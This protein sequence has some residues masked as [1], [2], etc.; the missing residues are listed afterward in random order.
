M[1]GVTKQFHALLL[2]ALGTQ[3]LGRGGSPS[4]HHHWWFRC[5]GY[6]KSAVFKLVRPGPKGSAVS[7]A[8]VPSGK[9]KEQGYSRQIFKNWVSR[10]VCGIREILGTSHL[11]PNRYINPTSSLVRVFKFSKTYHKMMLSDDEVNYKSYL[12]QTLKLFKKTESSRCLFSAE[13]HSRSMSPADAPPVGYD[14][15]TGTSTCPAAKSLQAQ[16]ASSCNPSSS[17]SVIPEWSL[18]IRLSNTKK[19]LLPVNSY[20][21]KF[22]LLK[23]KQLKRGWVYFGA[24]FQEMQSTSTGEGWWWGYEAGSHTEVTV[25]KHGAMDAGAHLIFSFLCG[26]EAQLTGQHCLY[27]A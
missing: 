4:L 18:Y 13:P 14:G 3:A 1:S 17:A 22:L 21:C 5:K 20:D 11:V 16:R 23:R 2:T 9:N 15:L 26:P 10:R 24:Q 25:R 12:P 7:T 19:M 8:L 6:S 27:L